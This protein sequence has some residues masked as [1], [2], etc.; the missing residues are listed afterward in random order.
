MQKQSA[1][2]DDLLADLKAFLAKEYDETHFF[3]YEIVEAN[4]RHLETLT[5]MLTE[6]VKKMK[7][8]IKTNG[9]RR[10]FGESLA[11]HLK[12]TERQFAEP[13]ETSFKQLR[14]IGL[15]IE[16]L[17]RIP[18][19]QNKIKSLAAA[20]DV[21][22]FDWERASKDVHSIA[23]VVKKYLRELPEPLIPCQLFDDFLKIGKNL[24]IGSKLSFASE[25]P[26]GRAIS[27]PSSASSSPSSTPTTPSTGSFDA[28]AAASTESAAA[29]T[30]AALAG[31][32]SSEK[33]PIDALKTLLKKL[34]KS[35]YDNLAF[36]MQFLTELADRSSEN[37]MSPSAIA[38]VIGPNVTW[39]KP[40]A[41]V[42]LG[43]FPFRNRAVEALITHF[44]ECFTDFEVEDV[45]DGREW[46][47]MNSNSGST[48]PTT[49]IDIKIANAPTEAE[50]RALTLEDCVRQQVGNNGYG[51]TLGLPDIE[52]LI[53]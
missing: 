31:T 15:G 35:H 24:R 52:H 28:A 3:V 6:E 21:G 29:A 47:R 43:S 10:V 37:K 30:A 34:P 9:K 23:G 27:K 48:T 39:P 46:K 25:S 33:V 1:L 16:G 20:F 5:A 41:E 44:R 22:I 4:R 14:R 12:D 45:I 53:E 49:P 2:L 17:F 13:L 18:G 32:A 11:D 50:K 26:T 40:P 7:T 36:L 51:V 8:T 38:T 19:G 42:D